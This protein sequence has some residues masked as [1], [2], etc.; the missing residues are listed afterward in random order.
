MHCTA[1]K[2]S[3]PEKS[4]LKLF[5]ACQN[6]LNLV[7]KKSPFSKQHFLNENLEAPKFQINS[8]LAPEM[9]AAG[10]FVEKIPGKKPQWPERNSPKTVIIKIN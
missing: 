6:L 9:F 5:S 10:E 1:H 3:N 2:V 4:F 8:F 7:K